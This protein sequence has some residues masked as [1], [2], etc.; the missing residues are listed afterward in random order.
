MNR[1]KISLKRAALFFAAVFLAVSIQVTWAADIS[2]YKGVF[3]NQRVRVYELTFNP[4]SRWAIRKPVHDYL[5]YV[6]E[7]DEFSLLHWDTT[8]GVTTAKAGKVLWFPAAP[9]LNSEANDS[10]T[11]VV[12]EIPPMPLRWKDDRYQKAENNGSTI[13]RVLVMEFKGGEKVD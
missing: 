7:G 2:V 6:I 8:E 4:G 11:T 10:D 13:V 1:S 3:E 5:I 9:K 12:K